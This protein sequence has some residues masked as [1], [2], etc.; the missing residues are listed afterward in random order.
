MAGQREMQS[1]GGKKAL[2]ERQGEENT[3]NSVDCKLEGRMARESNA[4]TH[5]QSVSSA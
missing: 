5:I 4:D 3:T 1:D 2:K